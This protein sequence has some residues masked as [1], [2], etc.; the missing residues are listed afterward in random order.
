MDEK[1]KN[2]TIDELMLS[3]WASFDRQSEDLEKWKAENK[4]TEEKWRIEAEKRQAE[5]E[6]RQAEYKK[7][8]IEA[9][10][11]Q[12]E[13]EKSRI[14][15]E[16]RS[17]KIDKQ[18]DNLNKLV[19][20]HLNNIGDVAE[21]YFFNSFEEGKTNFFGQK[22]EEIDKKVKGIKKGYKDEYDILLINGESI[23]I[24]EVKFHAHVNDLQ[25]VLRQAETFRVNFPYYENHKVYLGL[26]TMSFYPDLE[27]KC[28]ELGIA[29][30]KQVG[31]TIV[32]YD[33]PLKEY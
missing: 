10:K 32:I 14:E 26:A 11:R 6:K 24:I 8:Q 7:R 33:D 19:G 16:K 1:Y 13:F 31:E 12:A 9:E 21:E 20:N 17:A 29:I 23:G 22:F 28:K 30:I 15:A 3:V 2:K 27:A 5:Y 25:G 18:L 4:A